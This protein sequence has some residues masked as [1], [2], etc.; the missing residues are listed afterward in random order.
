MASSLYRIKV[1]VFSEIGP[2]FYEDDIAHNSLY[3]IQGTMY[4]KF[5]VVL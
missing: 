1:W 4:Y 5:L 2:H 3:L